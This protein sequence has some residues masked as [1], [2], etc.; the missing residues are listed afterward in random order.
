MQ[1]TKWPHGEKVA[2]AGKSHTRHLRPVSMETPEVELD[3]ACGEAPFD[4]WDF[5]GVA[6]QKKNTNIRTIKR[7]LLWATRSPSQPYFEMSLKTTNTPQRRL[8]A[9]E[10]YLEL[11]VAHNIDHSSVTSRHSLE[12]NKFDIIPYL[13]AELEGVRRNILKIILRR[14]K[15]HVNEEAWRSLQ[16][17]G[18][19]KIKIR[20][21]TK[22]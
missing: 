21:A 13:V 14:L 19:L 17:L 3:D 12:T 22:E 9:K 4:V 6:L 18:W 15:L 2:L 16:T 11:R 5:F 10:L 20:T 1:A 8:C 7:K